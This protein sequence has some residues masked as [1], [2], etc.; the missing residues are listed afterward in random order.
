[1][2]SRIYNSIKYRINHLLFEDKVLVSLGDYMYLRDDN[3]IRMYHVIIGSRILDIEQWEKTGEP[4][5]ENT[6]AISKVLFKSMNI[7][8]DSRGDDIRFLNLLESY[9]KKGFDPSSYIRYAKN[10]T[11]NDGTHRAALA[12]CYNINKL[13][14][15]LYTRMSPYWDMKIP[16]Y[17]EEDESC[18]TVLERVK[19]RIFKAQND[20]KE[21]GVLLTCAVPCDSSFPLDKVKEDLEKECTIVR[22]IKNE[23]MDYTLITLLPK[24]FDYYQ[25][26]GRLAFKAI[27]KLGRILKRKYGNVELTDN[28][29]DGKVVY[30]RYMN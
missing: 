20:L 16:A 6:N 22:V 10:F 9:R 30:D 12:F 24:N 4:L 28:F 8:H 13:P 5:F 27:T 14:G 11:I 3:S 19:Q 17:L 26:R 7:K 29:V 21:N 15:I 25:K 1:M 23:R 2:I 18:N